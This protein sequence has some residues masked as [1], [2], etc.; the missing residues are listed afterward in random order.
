MIGP[1]SSKQQELKAPTQEGLGGL[2]VAT[3][4]DEVQGLSANAATL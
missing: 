2:F 4:G 3:V 1:E